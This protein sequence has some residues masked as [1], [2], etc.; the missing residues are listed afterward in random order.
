[1]KRRF[2]RVKTSSLTG[3]PEKKTLELLQ[4]HQLGQLL[5]AYSCSTPSFEQ[6]E[7][8]PSLRINEKLSFRPISIFSCGIIEW[9]LLVKNTLYFSLQT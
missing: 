4:F 5:V 6:T 8:H 1:M 3:D 9:T 2:Y 7:G